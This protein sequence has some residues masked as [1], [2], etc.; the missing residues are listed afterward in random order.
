MYVVYN[1]VYGRVRARELN[2]YAAIYF[3]R[4]AR[5]RNVAAVA[6]VAV[7]A[8]V[9]GY[10]GSGIRGATPADSRGGS[11]WKGAWNYILS[12]GDPPRGPTGR[13]I[14]Y[15]RRPVRYI[16]PLYRV[17]YDIIIIAAAVYYYVL[18]KFA[19]CKYVYI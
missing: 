9:R 2:L 6:A 17:F 18:R 12:Y 16:P 3:H 1:I 15:D 10:R 13:F 8:V 7:T 19:A 4:R 11:V 5:A 14:I